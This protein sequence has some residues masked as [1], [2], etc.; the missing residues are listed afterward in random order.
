[1]EE[2]FRF[3]KNLEG[4]SVRELD[5]LADKATDN[6]DYLDALM[7][8][9]A[10]ILVTRDPAFIAKR[11]VIFRCLDEHHHCMTDAD[12]AENLDPS[13]HIYSHLR[14][15]NFYAIGNLDAATVCL[16]K[17]AS[18]NPDFECDKAYTELRADIAKKKLS[19]ALK[20]SKLK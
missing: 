9:T 6:K 1:M 20:N 16:D 7:F 8:I 10:A 17:A 4:L 2:K 11:A 13:H 15:L 3:Q 14:A 19:K 18:L 12:D 5:D